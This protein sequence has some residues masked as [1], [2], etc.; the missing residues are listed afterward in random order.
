LYARAIITSHL[1]ADRD[2]EAHMTA[3]NEALV[4]SGLRALRDPLAVFVCQGIAEKFGENWW[5]EGVLEV[6]IHDRTPTIEDVRKHRKLPASGTIDELA[7]ALDINGCLILLTKHW[8]RIFGPVLGQDHRGWAYELMGVRNKNKHLGSDDHPSDYAWRA[9]DTMYRLCSSIDEQS[10]ARLLTLRSSVD[11]SAFGQST[12]ISDVAVEPARE[13]VVA[14]EEISA[15]RDRHSSAD[16]DAE[17]LD[18]SADLAA[19]GPDFSGADLRAMNFMGADLA[20]ADFTNADLTDANLSGANLA[21][22]VFVGTQLGNADLTDTDLRGAIFESP[23]LSVQKWIRQDWAMV[24]ARLSGATL[25]GATLNFAGSD[26]RS[27]DLRGT[28][29]AGADFTNADLTDANLSGANLAGAVLKG[30]NIK[31]TITVDVKWA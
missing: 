6:F 24:G 10:A 23:T 7:S 25:D 14:S 28:N 26:L 3:T 12:A 30:A 5:T 31:T 16:A 21:G 8:A 19:A 27:T 1:E 17:E 2:E 29:L 15:E 4:A 9:L 13:T 18:L 11:L 22:A 20:G